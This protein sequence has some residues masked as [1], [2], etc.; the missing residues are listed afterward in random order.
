MLAAGT[1]QRTRQA[2]KKQAR[3]QMTQ[4]AATIAVTGTRV[5]KSV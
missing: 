1:D 4:M 3:A 5:V 2:L